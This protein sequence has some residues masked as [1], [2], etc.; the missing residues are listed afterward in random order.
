MSQSAKRR[1][2]QEALA[3]SGGTARRGWARGA[4]E[5]ALHEAAGGFARA[6]FADM[7]L[8][9]RWPDIVGPDI[10]RVAQPLKWQDGAEGAVLTLKCEGAARVLLQH[11]T[12]AILDALNAYLGAG[13][14]ARLRLVPGRLSAITQAS[15]HPAPDHDAGAEQ[16]DLSEALARLG[17]LRARLRPAGKRRPAVDPN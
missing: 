11:Q 4:G 9:L 13:R 16:L 7:S 17:A 5:S 3:E 2:P 14:V 6:G 15:T 10:A 12:R 1:K 8:V